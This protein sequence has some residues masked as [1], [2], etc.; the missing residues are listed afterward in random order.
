[1][2]AYEVSNDST[3]KDRKNKKV[4]LEIVGCFLSATGAFFWIG[5]GNRFLLPIS[6]KI[7]N[8]EKIVKTHESYK[9]NLVNLV[10]SYMVLIDSG[11]FLDY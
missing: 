3:K 11:L 9:I 4:I 2:N 1:M 10:K 8:S 5:N 7:T 6:I